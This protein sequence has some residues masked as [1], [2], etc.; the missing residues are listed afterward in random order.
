[1]LLLVGIP[2]TNKPTSPVRC[3]WKFQLARPAQLVKSEKTHTIHHTHTHTPTASTP[4]PKHNGKHMHSSKMQAVRTTWLLQLWL[5]PPLPLPLLPPCGAGLPASQR[6]H[7]HTIKQFTAAARTPKHTAHVRA[8][9]TSS[10]GLSKTHEKLAV[11]PLAFCLRAAAL[12]DSLRMRSGSL[13]RYSAAS[14][15]YGDTG[16]TRSSRKLSTVHRAVGSHTTTQRAC[17]CM[18]LNSVSAKTCAGALQARAAV[19]PEHCRDRLLCCARTAVACCR[20]QLQALLTS[21]VRSL[22]SASF[23]R[24]PRCSIMSA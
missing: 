11:V 3:P 20:D 16:A 9:Q 4:A 19:I 7:P 18:T 5:L 23:Q 22:R 13:V 6:T 17:C 1:M 10:T 15:A 2:T 21:P 8:A 24:L 14:Q 12:S